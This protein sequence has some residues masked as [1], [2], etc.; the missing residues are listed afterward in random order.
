M[1]YCFLWLVS[2]GA[3]YIMALVVGVNIMMFHEIVRI[4]QKHRKEAQ[5]PYF[6]MM[7]WYFLFVTELVNLIQVLREPLRLSFPGF[8]AYLKHH[9]IICFGL[10]VAGFVGFVLSLRRG[11][12]RYQMGQF[13]WM[14]MTLIFIVVQGAFSLRNMLRGLVWFLLPV[15]CVINNDIWAYIVGKFFGRTPL[16]RLSP[17]KTMEGFMGSWVVTMMWAFW[18]SGLMCQ[19]PALYCPKVDFHTPVMCE[20]PEL[21]EPAPWTLLG[22]TFQVAPVQWHALVFGAFASLIAPFGGFFASGLK[23]A[24]K[25]KDFGDLIPGHGG[26]TDRMDCQIIMGMFTY[27]YLHFVIYPQV[28]E[29][30]DVATIVECVKTLSGDQRALV[31]AALGMGG[32]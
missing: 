25:L 10:Y 19:F 21:F 8:D 5:M 14:A 7:P 26:M 11:L 27:V 13:T 3:T 6:R 16:L 15:T 29:R 24:F 12:Y 2:L 4:N 20:R 31:A 23:R 32:N 9:T 28:H 17:K 30:C 22:Q 1:A 18:F